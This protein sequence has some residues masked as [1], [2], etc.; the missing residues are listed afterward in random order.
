MISVA[1]WVT[2][3]Y[4]GSVCLILAIAVVLFALTNAPSETLDWPI[5]P[6]IGAVMR[7]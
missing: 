3:A 6:E 7:E 1:D 2:L 4:I 5:K